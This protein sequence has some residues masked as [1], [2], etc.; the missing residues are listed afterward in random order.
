[1]TKVQGILMAVPRLESG[2]WGA[3]QIDETFLVAKRTRFLL[4]VAENVRGR[5]AYTSL[6]RTGV[7]LHWLPALIPRG[8]EEMLVTVW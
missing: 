3:A 8:C 4:I 5:N 7:L 1:V 2:D 6:Q